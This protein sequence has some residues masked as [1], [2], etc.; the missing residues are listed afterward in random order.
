MKGGSKG[1]PS[2]WKE[3]S[4]NKD[5]F[6]AAFPDPPEVKDMGHMAQLPRGASATGYIAKLGEGSGGV[7]VVAL[8]IPMDFSVAQKDFLMGEFRRGMTSG[9]SKRN[10]VR[11]SQP[12]QVTWAGQKA[13]E[14]TMEETGPGKSG[15]AVIRYMITEGG[16]YIAFVGTDTGRLS[17]DIENAFFDSFRLLK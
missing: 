16:G 1:L 3:Y 2:G 11:L 7:F 8:Q 10:N 13:E 12:R 9:A 4:F 17:S 14:V 6:K 5:K 15:G